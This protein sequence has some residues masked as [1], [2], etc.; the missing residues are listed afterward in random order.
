M[1][2]QRNMKALT[3][4]LSRFGN[5]RL[6]GWGPWDKPGRW[7]ETLTDMAQSRCQ[8]RSCIHA[9]TLNAQH[10]LTRHTTPYTTAIPTLGPK[11]IIG[12]RLQCVAVPGLTHLLGTKLLQLEPNC[13][14]QPV[15]S[16]IC[17]YVCTFGWPKMPQK[18]LL[19]N[20]G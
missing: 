3:D 20:I 7:L 4:K 14:M 9:A 5:C 8:W 19:Q 1:T 15:Q 2:W 12:Y 18:G 11:N 6:P 10:S 16:C 17:I 13:I